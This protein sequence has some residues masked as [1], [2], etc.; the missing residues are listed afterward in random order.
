MPSAYDLP[1][2]DVPPVHDHRKSRRQAL[3]RRRKF[4]SATAERI[5]EGVEVKLPGLFQAHKQVLI[6]DEHMPANG[7]TLKSQKFFVR[8]IFGGA[9]FAER[10]VIA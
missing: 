5:V 6:G 3:D 10:R 8:T 4:S 2:G 7:L 1:S 9:P